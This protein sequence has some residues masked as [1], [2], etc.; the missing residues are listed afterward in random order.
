MPSRRR[1]P[2]LPASELTVA[3]AAK[4]IGMT[5]NGVYTAIKARRIPASKVRGQIVVARADAR[6]YRRKTI[7]W[8]RE[9]LKARNPNR[10]LTDEEFLQRLWDNDPD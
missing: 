6:E 5:P 1:R 10:K 4:L 8:Y 7:A 9:A 3:Q 2:R